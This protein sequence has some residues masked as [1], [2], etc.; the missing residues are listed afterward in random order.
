MQKQPALHTPKTYL[1]YLVNKTYKERFRRTKTPD[2]KPA[3]AYDFG[4]GNFSMRYRGFENP[5][6]YI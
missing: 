3:S 2:V 1:I 4:T 6:L 5:T